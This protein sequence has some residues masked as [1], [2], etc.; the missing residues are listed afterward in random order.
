MPE[1]RASLRRGLLRIAVLDRRRIPG[2]VSLRVTRGGHEIH[3]VRTRVEKSVYRV[4]LRLRSRRGAGRR[5]VVCISA[6]Y[7]SGLPGCRDKAEEES[8]VRLYP[9]AAQLR[10][11]RRR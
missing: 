11:A 3:A 10:P 2:L 9:T 4:R 6:A 8:L 1:V 7:G 5:D